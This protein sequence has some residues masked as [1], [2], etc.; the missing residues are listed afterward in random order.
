M[1]LS[2]EQLKQEKEINEKKVELITELSALMKKYDADLHARDARSLLPANI[3]LDIRH[4]G[5]S[6]VGFAL[7]KN[8]AERI[9]KEGFLK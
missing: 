2:N 1:K 3:Y 5:S 7:D 9:I 6:K 8:T 4:T